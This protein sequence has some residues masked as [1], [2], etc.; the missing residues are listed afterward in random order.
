M[1]EDECEEGVVDV[2]SDFF[3]FG[4]RV[5]RPGGRGDAFADDGAECLD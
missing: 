5:G 4:F 3:G 1:D 2:G